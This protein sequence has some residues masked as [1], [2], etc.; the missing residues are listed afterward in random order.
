MNKTT[1]LTKL[2]LFAVMLL[3]GTNLA[4]NPI[5]AEQAKK[6]AAQ[7]ITSNKRMASKSGRQLQLAFT[8]KQD[9]S[10][11]N[12]QMPAIYA[13]N[14]ANDG[15]FVIVSGDDMAKPVL[16]YASQGN[17]S[18]DNMP[19]N[20]RY[21]LDRY[22]N[23]I[24]WAQAN[25]YQ[26]AQVVAASGR[27]DVAYMV[28]TTW[29]QDDPYWSQCK[30][31]NTY[32][33]TG[34][35]A[36][37]MAQ[38][39]YYWGVTGRNGE[40]FQHGCNA[41]PQYTTDTEG[42]TVG[43]LSTVISFDWEHMTAG[44]PSSNDE[45]TAVAQ[46]MRYCGQSVYMD[47]T[48]DG[49]GAYSQDIPSALI[50]K[51]G[52][53][54]TARIVYHDNMTA[55]KWE[56]LIYAE[57]EAGRPVCLGGADEVEEIGH[58][59]VCDGY[60]ASTGLFHINWGWSGFFDNYFALD[61]LEP[62]GT[63]S[64]GT[65]SDMGRYNDGCDAIIGIEPPAGS[66]Q[67]G[68]DDPTQVS[69]NFTFDAT[70]DVGTQGGSSTG[71]DQVTKNGV[72]ISVSPT[73]SFGNKNQYRVYKG[74]TFTMTS[75]VGNIVKVEFTCTAEGTDKYGP[76][77]FSDPTVGT[78]TYE[79][80]VGTWTGCTDEFS[81]T[82]SAAQVRITTI[83]VYLE[84]QTLMGDVN[85][86]GCVD[87]SDVLLIVDEILGKNPEGFI[88]ANA[89]INQDDVIDISDVLLVVDIILGKNIE[90]EWSEWR[91]YNDEGTCVYYYT[92]YWSGSE[93]LKFYVRDNNKTTNLHQF[94]IDE[95]GPGMTLILD[96]DDE[97][98]I[99][100]VKDQYLTDND[101]YGEV[102]ICDT[103]YYLSEILKVEQDPVYGYFDEEMGIIGIPIAYYVSDGYFGYDYEYIYLD[104]FDRPD[105]AAQISYKGEET[106]SSGTPWIVAQVTLG[107]DVTSARVAL[108]P[109][110]VTEEVVDAIIAGTFEPMQTITASGE[111]RF[112]AK[113]LED[114][115]Y[116][117]IVI[118][119]LEEVA[120]ALDYVNFV[121][122][123]SSSWT[124]LGLG[125]LTEDGLTTFFKIDP[126]TYPVEILENVNM[127]GLY[128]IVNPYGAA[129][130][131]NEE[132]DWDNSR[133]WNI[134]VDA[135]DPNGVF[136]LKQETGLDW[137][138]G[139]FII[140]SLGAYYMEDGGYGFDTVKN[141]GMMGTLVDGHITFPENGLV[142]RLGDDYGPAY[143][144]TNQAYE[145][146]LPESASKTKA[147][148]AHL[149]CLKYPIGKKVSKIVRKAFPEVNVAQT[150]YRQL[151]QRQY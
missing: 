99:V 11:S 111:V 31:R 63:G 129:F 24:A 51:F 88:R 23:Q 145:I 146:V 34:C 1:I 109:N 151:K 116:S 127:P 96:Y 119:Y 22:A 98:G 16:G 72:T 76:G 17:I 86:D 84:S 100:S 150:S 54:N 20:M 91:P 60:Q 123:L 2:M 138:Y 108:V 13:Y 7:F 115:N 89:D 94:R 104:G 144:N 112:S 141:A 30:F 73:G 79:G 28:K 42:Y 44:R 29:D 37:A 83:N 66:S 136:I 82:A 128:R 113:D 46:L 93:Q 52:Y 8:L 5:T 117:L 21:W 33:Y 148:K 106:D 131:Y 19:D 6:N 4:A 12:V 36:T 101:T 50:D 10:A 14:I 139:M 132:G 107:A 45:K 105:V 47:Y 69:D 142:V 48:N 134:E 133:D 78:Y 25:G 61:A 120:Q 130:P 56:E 40:K 80:K 26:P 9:K 85:N 90:E 126:V 102:R 74:S 32:C 122:T 95:W 41:L 43:A 149:S 114:G 124:S 55:T 57:M 58:E 70:K 87:I 38:I 71:E 75:T 67:G 143:G 15:G 49:S 140:Q 125:S 97:T 18:D 68:D 137:G 92:N 77:C 35:V 121:Y 135:Q 53:G 65:E 147:V 64:G 27:K 110:S 81:M 118:S 103:Y 3:W 62:G 59:F 39:M